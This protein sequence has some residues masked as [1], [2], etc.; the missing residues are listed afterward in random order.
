MNK[1]LTGLRADN[2]T[3]VQEIQSYRDDYQ[4]MVLE[5]EAESGG[6]EIDK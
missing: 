2:A 3:L 5:M 6:Q 4:R 1:E